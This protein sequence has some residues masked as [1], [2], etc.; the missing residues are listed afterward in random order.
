[1]PKP[2][3]QGPA[4]NPCRLPPDAGYCRR[5]CPRWYYDTR[6]RSCRPFNYGCCGGNANN[7]KTWQLCD[8]ICREDISCTAQAC[9][10]LACTIQTCPNFPEATCFAPCPCSSVWIY[11]GEDVTERCNNY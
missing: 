8:T 5:I 9:D 10:V 7:F 2:L 4:K 6:L 11:N 3:Q 1:M